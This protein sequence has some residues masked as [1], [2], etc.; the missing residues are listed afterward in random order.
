MVKGKTHKPLSSSVNECKE[1]MRVLGVTFA[2]SPNSESFHL[3]NGSSADT[4]F[5]DIRLSGK[6]ESHTGEV[7]DYSSMLKTST[8]LAWLKNGPQCL[9]PIFN[10][11]GWKCCV[12][13]LNLFF[14]V[15]FTGHRDTPINFLE[16]L[17]E[18]FV[19]FLLRGLNV[20]ILGYLNCNLFG[21][22]PDGLAL[23]DFLF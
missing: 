22:D 7:L 15:Q 13:N 3:W 4:H 10:N 12:I 5:G 23:S 11:C 14:S 8:R 21:D 18:T 9:K 19:D 6:I 17:S 1:I 16:N 20:L 2:D